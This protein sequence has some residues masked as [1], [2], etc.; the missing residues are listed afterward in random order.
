MSRERVM[1]HSEVTAQ[2][3]P[4]ERKDMEKG[5]ILAM[6]EPRQQREHCAVQSFSP[7]TTEQH[8]LPSETHRD[9]RISPSSIAL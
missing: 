7:H 9:V 8:C 2:P 3:P 4:H 5:R 1:L 6:C